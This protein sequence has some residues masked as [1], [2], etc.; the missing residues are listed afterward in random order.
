MLNNNIAIIWDFDGTLTPEDSTSKTIEILAGGDN[1]S[2]LFWK[3]VKSLKGLKDG[4]EQNWEHILA[5]DA[6]IWMY[7]LSELAKAQNV[8]LNEQYFR[9]F[10]VPSIKLYDGVVSFLKDIKSLEDRVDFKGV[11]LKIHHF[12]VSAG[13]KDLIGQVFE[14]NLVTWTFGCRYT[15]VVEGD[16]ENSPPVSVPVYC[17]DETYK[18]RSI[19]EIAKGVFEKSDISVNKRVEQKDLWCP[20]SN[21]IYIGDG[22]TDVP[23]LS[24]VRDKGGMGIAVFDPSWTSD[25]K[26]S[27]FKEMR[28]DKRADLIT[29]ADFSLGAE[30]HN[31]IL[32]RCHQ[33][34]Q[35]YEASH[36]IGRQS[37]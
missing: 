36:V 21:M 35:R 20:F 34:R 29:A 5:M 9:E 31:Y 13:L 37:S 25:K 1:E 33:I 3:R 23:S 12:I 26:Q 11:N 27:R 7:T 6:P 14:K 32:N 28:L 15:I 17:V 30:L 24:L 2:D 16:D 22:P 18:T 19:F 10:V 8:P 4:K